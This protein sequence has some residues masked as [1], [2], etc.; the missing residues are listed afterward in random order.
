MMRERR[1]QFAVVE[2]GARSRWALMLGGGL[3]AI[4]LLY[5]YV[6]TPHLSAL[7]LHLSESFGE[8]MA[9]GMGL[10]HLVYWGLE[11]MKLAGAAFLMKLCYSDIASA[12]R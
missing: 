9:P 10:L 1:D 3:L 12:F 11:A 2:S 5:T 6:L 7:G 8:P 4:A